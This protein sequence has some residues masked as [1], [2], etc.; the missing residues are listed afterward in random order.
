M[1]VDI[2]FI[3][4]VLGLTVVTWGSYMVGLWVFQ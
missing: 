2:E 4:E 3:L 1:R